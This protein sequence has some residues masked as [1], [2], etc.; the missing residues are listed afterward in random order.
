MSIEFSISA[1]DIGQFRELTALFSEQ[2]ASD[3]RL[4]SAVYSEWLYSKNPFGLAEIVTAEQEGS[5]LGFMA[6][7]PI[8]LARQDEVKIAYFAVNVFVH[9]KQ[10][11][12]KILGFMIDE[13]IKH[14]KSKRAILMGHPNSAAYGAWERAAMHFQPPLKSYFVMPKIVQ[15]D[16]TF[17]EVGKVSELVK[18]ISQF[19]GQGQKSQE[20]QVILSEDYLEWRYLHHPTNDYCLRA[21]IVKKD[22]VGVMVTKKVRTSLNILIDQFALNGHMDTSFGCAP[23][24]TVALLPKAFRQGSGRLWGVPA[25]KE[26]PFFCTDYEKRIGARELMRLGLSASDF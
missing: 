11:G 3:D 7:I 15:W 9:P 26:I 5:W 8:C 16:A 21:I 19:N 10:R 1:F 6:L 24:L 20:W 12:K 25:E 2:F 23:W 18:F 4:L 22:T 17:H 14:V 13:A